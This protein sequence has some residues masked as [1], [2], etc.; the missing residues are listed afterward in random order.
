MDQRPHAPLTMKSDD[1]HLSLAGRES[2]GFNIEVE[3]AGPEGLKQSPMIPGVEAI[4]EIPGVM[5]VEVV[6]C[7]GQLGV[8][9]S[10]T[11]RRDT[12]QVG[13]PPEGCPIGDAAFPQTPLGRWPD[14]F[15][16]D[17][18]GCQHRSGRDCNLDFRG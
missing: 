18:R 2:C 8:V 5:Q 9:G 17:K 13:L 7:K 15:S 3:R 11:R 14:T 12:G 16:M 1:G 4:C 6:L 10:F